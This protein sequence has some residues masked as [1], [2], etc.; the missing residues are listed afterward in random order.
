MSTSYTLLNNYCISTFVN[1]QVKYFRIKIFQNLYLV[2]SLHLVHLKRQMNAITVDTHSYKNSC[3]MT[4]SVH[5]KSTITT[6]R[7]HTH[8]KGFSCK[9]LQMYNFDKLIFLLSLPAHSRT[10][11]SIT[12]QRRAFFVRGGLQFISLTI[13]SKTSLTLC[14]FLALASLKGQFQ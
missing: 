3:Y 12:Q 7:E 10:F 4:N 13:T 14:L 9:V 11:Q 2:S 5:Y 6:Y 1:T 8:K